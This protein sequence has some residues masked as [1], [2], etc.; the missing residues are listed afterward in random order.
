MIWF[1]SRHNRKPAGDGVKRGI[2]VKTTNTLTSYGYSNTYE[3]EC[4]VWR[5]RHSIGAAQKERENSQHLSRL[6]TLKMMFDV[7]INRVVG[8]NRVLAWLD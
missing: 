5:W 6:D 8:V 3:F 1:C 4:G 2:I 7:F